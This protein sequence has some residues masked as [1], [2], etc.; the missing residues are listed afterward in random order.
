MFVPLIW[1]VCYSCRLWFVCINVGARLL[2][3]LVFL[4]WFS[5]VDVGDNCLFDVFD[6]VVSFIVWLYLM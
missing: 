6:L 5:V 3:G 1:F 2:S 4:R